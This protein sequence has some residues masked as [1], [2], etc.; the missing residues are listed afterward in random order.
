MKFIQEFREGDN[1]AGIYFCKVKNELRTKADKP[2]FSVQLQ[3]KTGVVDAKIWH[4][5]L[6]LCIRSGDAFPVCPPA[7]SVPCTEMP[8]GGIQSSRLYADVLK[9]H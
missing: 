9:G 2:Y 4:D 5:G 1:I 3:D 6:Y 7:Q 8:G